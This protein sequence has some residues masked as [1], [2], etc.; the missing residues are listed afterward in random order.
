[1]LIMTTPVWP[2]SIS[3]SSITNR[4]ISAA[5]RFAVTVAVPGRIGTE[6]GRLCANE[7]VVAAKITLDANA[8]VLTFIVQSPSAADAYPPPNAMT[9]A[10]G[11]PSPCHVAAATVRSAVSGI[12]WATGVAAIVR[13]ASVTAVVWTVSVAA[14]VWGRN[15]TQQQTGS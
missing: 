12:V 15:S 4:R 2:T 3:I 8:R 13:T 9:V 7:A 6:F 10:I 14:P 11:H 1:M 5:Y